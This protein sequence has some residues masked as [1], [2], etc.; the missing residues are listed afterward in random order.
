MARKNFR[1]YKKVFRSEPHN[2]TSV[3]TKKGNELFM[4]SLNV[5]YPIS[6][7]T[8]TVAY[9]S[10]EGY[11]LNHAKKRII[12]AESVAKHNPHLLNYSL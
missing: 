6:C 11:A 8:G 2:F 12:D 1:N 5:P 7:Y 9:F 4:V 3:V 10:K